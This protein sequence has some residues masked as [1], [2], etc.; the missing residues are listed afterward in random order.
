MIMS[1]HQRIRKPHVGGHTQ[2]VECHLGKQSAICNEWLP[3]Y[4]D[5]NWT[6]GGTGL[7]HTRIKVINVSTGQKA[8]V[9]L[10]VNRQ[11]IIF[12]SAL[13]NVILKMLMFCI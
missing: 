1:R 13:L 11:P 4:L 7:N 2:T 9:T 5:R 12:E 8:S 6:S 3:L 10:T